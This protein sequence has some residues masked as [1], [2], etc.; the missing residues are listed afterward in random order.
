SLAFKLKLFGYIPA[1]PVVFLRLSNITKGVLQNRKIL[2]HSCEEI[3][4]CSRKLAPLFELLATSCR[5]GTG[6]AAEMPQLARLAARFTF[7]PQRPGT[8]YE[9]PFPVPELTKS[10]NL[11]S[12][13]AM[14]HFRFLSF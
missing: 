7:H 11:C 10:A 2:Q 13:A 6:K 9:L 5:G 12:F 4:S 1:Q 3:S 8:S 14:F